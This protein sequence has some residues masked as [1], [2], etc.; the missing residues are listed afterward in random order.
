MNIPVGA[1]APNQAGWVMPALFNFGK[2]WICIT[3]TAVDTNYCGS[4]LSQF[5]SDGEYSIQFPQPQEARSGEPFL[6]E[7]V[8]PWYTPWRIIAVTD[9]MADLVESTLETDLAIPARYDV[10][11]WLQPGIASWSWVILKDSAT[12]YNTQRQFIDFAASMN[13][14]YC[15]IDAFWDTKIGYEKIK[16]LADYA[17]TKNVKILLWTGGRLEY[18]STYS[19]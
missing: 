10:S 14:R 4:R 16:Q 13:W 17:E 9:N 11:S 3:E 12:E 15:L 18:N 5:S 19:P 8:L 6:P 7:S 2:Y 1:I